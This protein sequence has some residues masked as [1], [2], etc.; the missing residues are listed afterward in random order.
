MKNRV[1]SGIYKGKASW[2]PGCFGFFG[3]SRR[4]F[5]E[6]ASQVIENIEKKEVAVSLDLTL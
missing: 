3:E 4:R 2:L 6:T 1:K 5:P